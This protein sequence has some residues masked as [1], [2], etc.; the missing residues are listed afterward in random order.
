MSDY[1]Q[2]QLVRRVGVRA[3]AELLRSYDLLVTP[4]TLV[5]APKVDD[6]DLDLADR[7]HPHALLECRGLPTMSVPM[8]LTPLGL[9]SRGVAGPCHHPVQAPPRLVATRTTSAQRREPRGGL[10]VSSGDSARPGVPARRVT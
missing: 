1:V 2:A 6:L 7:L 5:P 9:T 3:I 10:R 8:G 4:T